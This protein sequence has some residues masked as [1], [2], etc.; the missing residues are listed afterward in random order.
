VKNKANRKTLA[1][2]IIVSII[3]GLAA[4]VFGFIGVSPLFS[5]LGTS[6]TMAGRLITTIAFFLLASFV[7][8]SSNFRH[9]WLGGLVSWGGVM[10]GL[11]AIIR[12][13]NFEI[14]KYLAIAIAPSFTGAFLGRIVGERRLIGW[15]FHRIFCRSNPKN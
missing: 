3:S 12:G 7:V 6:E 9:W 1:I 5:D 8:S 2:D 13:P 11:G 15:L 14:L 10:L 4:L